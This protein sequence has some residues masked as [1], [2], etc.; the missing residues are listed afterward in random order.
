MP[1]KCTWKVRKQMWYHFAVKCELRKLVHVCES[2]NTHSG[3]QNVNEVCYYDT[4]R[5]EKV[6][7]QTQTLCAG[8]SKAEPKIFTSLQTPFSGAG[9]LKFNPLEMVTTFTYRPVWWRQ[10]HAISSYHG[11]RTT[12]IQT[13]KHTQTD[14]TD[15]ATKLSAQRNNNQ[16]LKSMWFLWCNKD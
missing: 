10:M 6:V 11:N 8:C 4:H 7:R 5:N 1:K 14:R 15:H 16:I 13:H 3:K 9:W 2:I 12:N